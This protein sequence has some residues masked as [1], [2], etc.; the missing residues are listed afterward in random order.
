[1]KLNYSALKNKEEW[2]LKNIKT[3]LFDVEAVR[4]ETLEVPR[5]LH[6][7]AGNIF[8]AFIASCQDELLNR[9]LSKTGII[10][11]ETFDEAII[12]E[13]YKPH[14][15]LALVTTLKETGEIENK[16][17]ASVVE[18]FKGSTDFSMLKEIF[19][20]SSLQM[21]SF[22]IT[23]KGYAIK[24]SQGEL[25]PIITQ[26]LS[27]QFSNPKH[28]MSM[29]TALLFERF[30]NGA[31]PITLVSMDNCSHNGDKLR[32]AVIELGQQ[33]ETQA[34][35][36]KGF[37]SYISDVTKVS[38][39]L[40]MIDKITPRPSEKIGESLQA[41][42]FEDTD[43]VI[44]EKNTYMAPFVN[45]EETQY[46]VIEDCFTNGRPALDEATGVIFTDRAT[47]N[48]VETMKV[49][50]CLNPLHTALAIFGCLLDYKTISD[51]MKDEDLSEL[52]RQMAYNEGLKAVIDPGIISPNEF[53]NEVLN[54]RFPNEFIVD[55]PQRIATDTSQK[56]GI[57]YG[58]T[59]RSYMERD[60]LNVQ[61]L[62]LIPL[63]IAGWLKYLDG[64]NDNGETFE[65]SPD[66]MMPQLRVLKE[67]KRQL[68][69]NKAIFGV[70]LYKIGLGEKIASI[71]EEMSA[72]NGGIRA[73]VKKY[74]IQE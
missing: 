73:T 44:T 37:V 61:D 10:A 2:S 16:V 14:D 48:N 1:M 24:D 9:G 35:D 53:V 66:P 45:A 55:T 60:D 41:L 40:T 68:L 20:K 26:D 57:R 51:E 64:I 47:V 28:I 72:G 49:T 7:G 62:K 27:S 17:V 67:D 6:F 69:S 12:D 25:L 32:A 63:V 70:D 23:E 3:P 21:V 18:S 4:A 59:I 46:L 54:K 19:K 52:V 74:L 38:F 34:R 65:L 31:D 29:I 22:T 36:I 13:I 39:P 58:V 50:T 71:Y 56:L 5:W 15:N 43:I 33:L 11:V 8:R 30:L 42:G